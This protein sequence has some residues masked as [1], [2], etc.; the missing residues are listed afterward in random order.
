M[1]ASGRLR[2]VGKAQCI[3]L[4]TAEQIRVL[5]GVLSRSDTASVNESRALL[6]SAMSILP[7]FSPGEN[8]EKRYSQLETTES[9]EVVSLLQ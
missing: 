7:N 1:A 9:Q 3:R 4:L 8:Q 2:T 6:S 5:L